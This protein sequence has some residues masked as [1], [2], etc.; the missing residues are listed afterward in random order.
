MPTSNERKMLSSNE[1]LKEL[2]TIADGFIYINL[3][4]F[5]NLVEMQYDLLV[6]FLLDLSIILFYSVFIYLH[7]KSK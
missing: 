5:N 7:L 4:R 2:I 3:T 1:A 6:C